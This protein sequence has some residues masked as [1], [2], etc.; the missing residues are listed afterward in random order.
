VKLFKLGEFGFIDR[1]KRLAPAGRGVEQGIG[2]DCAVIH[3]DARRWLL[4]TDTLVEGVHFRRA[5]DSA[6]GLGR[7]AFAVNASDIAAMGGRPRFA[8]L[9]V[10]VPGSVAASELEGV[11]RGFIR[12]ARA[13][14]CA[15]VGGNLSSA[16]QWMISVTLAGEPAGAPLLRAGAHPG[17]ALYV[18]GVVGAAAFGREIL[19]RRRRASLRTTRAF[20]RPEPRLALGELLSRR[21]LASAAIDVSDGLLQDL[22]HLCGASGVGVV[23]EVNRLPL[24][25]SLRPLPRKRALELALGGGEDYELL[26]TVPAAKEHRTVVAARPVQSIRRIGRIVEGRGIKLVDAS[27][28]EVSAGRL[29]FDHFKRKIK[30]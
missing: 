2:D 29:G 20:L 26:F 21:R 7:K 12:A 3:F 27:G 24:A 5:W 11:H 23:V 6:E 16:P 1:L 14:G 28:Q 13:R 15:L 8:L 18:S 19:L 25:R 10:A 22:G 9:S 30:K 17:D 4:T